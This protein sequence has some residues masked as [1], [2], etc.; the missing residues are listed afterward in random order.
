MVFES[1]GD[2]HQQAHVIY[3][4]RRPAKN[5]DRPDRGA[6]VAWRLE[7]GQRGIRLLTHEVGEVVQQ[8]DGLARGGPFPATESNDTASK[9]PKAAKALPWLTAGYS[10]GRIRPLVW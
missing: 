1:V 5:A 10:T 7:Y 4:R 6:D 8:I 9:R 3:R 2:V